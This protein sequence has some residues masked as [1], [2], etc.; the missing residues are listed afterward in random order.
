MRTATI[1]SDRRYPPRGALES[2]PVRF[3]SNRV[4]LLN[5]L[6]KMG[7]PTRPAAGRAD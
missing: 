3:R 4:E 6:V 7:F 5:N 2:A 1:L